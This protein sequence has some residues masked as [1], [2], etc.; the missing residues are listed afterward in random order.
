MSSRLMV[1]VD[2]RVC[3]EPQE[4]TFVCVEDFHKDVCAQNSLC[5]RCFVEKK[6]ELGSLVPRDKFPVFRA[7]VLPSLAAIENDF[8]PCEFLEMPWA[9]RVIDD[10]VGE[11]PEAKTE[12]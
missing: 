3:Q 2:C 9:A 7:E 5:M 12:E 8:D 1:R 4:R 6:Y 11:S 10:R